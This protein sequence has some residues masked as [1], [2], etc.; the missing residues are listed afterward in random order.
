MTWQRVCKEVSVTLVYFRLVSAV[1]GLKWGDDSRPAVQDNL[2]SVSKSNF[3]E[4]AMSFK[5]L[6]TKTRELLPVLMTTFALLLFVGSL[7]AQETTGALQGTVKD[8][9]GAVVSNAQVVATSN[10][11]VGNKTTNTDASGYYRFANM[12]PGSYVVTVT[13]KGFRT[14]KRDG[15]I[16]EVG[17][18]PTVDITLEVGGTDTVVE[19]SGAAPAI[20]V[21]QNTT[22]TNITEDVVQEVPH[23]RSFQSVIQFAPSARNEPLEGATALG[24]GTGS[25][26]PGN[27]SNGSAYGFSVAGGSDSENS[28]LVEGQE[29]ANLIGGYSH[30]NVPFDFIQ[31]VQI[32]SSGIEAEHGGA[33][34]GVVNVVMR[35]GS[36][37]YHGSAFMQF[38][39]Q[40]M[41]GSPIAYSRYDPLAIGTNASWGFI[42]PTYQNYQPIKPK[43]SDVFPGFTFG[44]PLLKDKLFFFLGFTPEWTDEERKVF[45]G[46]AGTLPF[47]RNT[48]TYYTTARV[49]ASLTQKIRVF[50][51]WL[52]QYQRQAGENL[53][54]SDSTTGFVNF[55]TGCFGLSGGGACAGPPIPPSAYSHAQGYSAPNSTTNVGADIT[56]NQHIVATTRFGYYFENYHDFG[57]P[58]GGSTFEWQVNSIGGVSAAPGCNNSVPGSCPALPAS[59]QY[60]NGWY[61]AGLDQN[62]T[63][64]NASKA[65][66]FDQ[67]LAWFKSGWMGTH[68]FKFGYQLNRLSNDIFQRFNQP[69]SQMFAG[70]SGGTNY[71]VQTAAGGPACALLAATVG[72]GQCQGSDGYIAVQDF[73]TE[74]KATSFNH[75]FFVQDAWTIGHGVTI[76]AGL[77]I[78]REYLPGE[79]FT[80]ETNSAIPVG[81]AP[82]HPIDFSWGSKIAPRIGAAWDVFKDG[83]MKVF[84]SYGVFNDQMKLNLAIS[85]F[86]G[87][88]WQNCYYALNTTNYQSIVP[89][90]NNSNPSRY[91]VGPSDLSTANWAGGVQPAGVSFIENANYRTWPT[92]C[93]T[94][95]QLQEG[96]MPDIQPY[97]QHESVFGTDYQISKNLA[98]EARWDR[99]RLDH[100]IEDSAIYN[101]VIGETFVI[102]NPGQGADKTFSSFYNFLY[103]G[104]AP[105][106]N[107]LSCSAAAPCPPDHIIPGA[108][109]YDGLEFRLNKASHNNWFGMFS[110]TYSKLRGNYTGLTSS[111]IADGGYAGRNSPNNSRSFDEPYF[112]WNAN[113]GSSSGLLPTDRTNTF[114]GYAYYTLPWSKLSN[115]LTS[116]FGIFQYLYSGSPVTTYADVGLG[117]SAWPVDLVNRGKWMDITQNPTTGLV[118]V[119]APRTFRTPW[120]TQS[121]FNF[122]QNYKISEQKV[123]SFSFVAANLLNQRAVTAYNE[124]VDTGYAYQGLSPNGAGCFSAAVGPCYP[125]NGAPFYA[126]AEA[127]Y[128]ISGLLNNGSLFTPGPITLNSQYGKPLYYQLARTFRLGV[129]FTF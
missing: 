37:A 3:T 18:L 112:S 66:Q 125:P 94:C 111:D 60:L 52:Y 25:N 101:P 14:S 72:N 35:K 5:R 105:P 38:E 39:N 128:S 73:G 85:S 82:S 43:T 22:Q 29:T 13:A 16:I 93:S 98:F 78:E 9:S 90:F 75:S 67:D 122:T 8:P 1:L 19:V 106:G 24:N 120:Y 20:D 119:G 91:C 46:S 30:T 47:S 61:N 51:S 41:D 84:G 103:S 104:A 110:Y 99:R 12:P 11:L 79:K 31:E 2:S 57:F 68:N 36:N 74:G 114:K 121:D 50:G 89:V 117:G 81:T 100:V 28:Y 17:H 129:K 127:P 116:D 63:V 65:L 76:N 71:G 4:E 107:K 26:S 21:T 33:L 27:S 10:I 102:V 70:Y 45:E 109:S 44:G 108:R 83:R 113:G 124:Q 64:R 56:I 97:R 34:G 58:Q 87:Q 40:G 23:G 55:S 88:W 49:D 7:F 54:R 42:D 15:L 69:F 86:G 95:S 48:Q 118:T 59:L 53:P 96:V 77:R 92:T 32:K 6:S 62:F 80:G 126:A 123:V 115:K